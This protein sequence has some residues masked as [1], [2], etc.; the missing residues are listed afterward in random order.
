MA[1]FPLQRRRPSSA[2][3]RLVRIGNGK[4]NISKAHLNYVFDYSSSITSLSM[5]SKC[6]FSLSFRS[7]KR[8]GEGRASRLKSLPLEAFLC[9]V[10]KMSDNCERSPPSVE[11]LPKHKASVEMGLLSLLSTSLTCWV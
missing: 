11:L 3:L 8:L 7:R 6:S 9:S 2:N 4:N 5:G 10:V 1:L